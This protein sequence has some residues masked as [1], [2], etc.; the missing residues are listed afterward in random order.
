MDVEEILQ[1]PEIVQIHREPA[2][3]YYIPFPDKE[4]ALRMEK[5]ESVNYT[6]L[7]GDW[8]F[9]YFSRSYD[10]DDDVFQAGIPSRCRPTGRCMGMISRITPT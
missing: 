8:A 5:E 9:A 7:G 2:R 4:N 6:P 3:A 1:N 10:V